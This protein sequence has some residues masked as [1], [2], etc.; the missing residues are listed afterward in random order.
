[1]G[2]I[3][4]LEQATREHIIPLSLGGANGF[5]IMVDSKF[6]SLFGAKI[7]GVLANDFLAKT[8]RQN[9]D[10]L[11]H[12]KKRPIVTIKNARM[13]KSGAP[14][15]VVLDRKMRMMSMYD[16]VKKR[17]LSDDETAGQSLSMQI[18]INRWARLRFTAKVALATGY[19]LYKDLFVKNVAHDEIRTIMNMLDEKDKAW[20]KLIKT[21]VYDQFTVP[22]KKDKA[23]FDTLKYLCKFVN[24]SFVLVTPGPRNVGFVVGVLGDMVGTLNVPAITKEFP[25]FDDHDLGHAV[26]LQKGNVFRM[27]FRALLQKA[28]EHLQVTKNS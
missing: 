19:F 18:S 23:Q 7:D 20:S 17:Y 26:V 27:S 10:A 5:E 3:I 25:R 16:P 9:F 22:N 2:H 4:P 11:G 1:M 12:S 15:Q 21:R 8:Q 28:H 6:N 13:E 24:G 14:I